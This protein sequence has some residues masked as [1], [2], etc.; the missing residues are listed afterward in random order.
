M[1]DYTSTLNQLSTGSTI[2]FIYTRARDGINIK[3]IRRSVTK[4]STEGMSIIHCIGL[5]IGIRGV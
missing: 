4:E 1:Y 3:E 5:I 2:Y